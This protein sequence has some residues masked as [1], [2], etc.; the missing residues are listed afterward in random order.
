MSITRVQTH[1]SFM[2]SLFLPHRPFFQLDH[3]TTHNLKEAFIWY[4][5]YSD[6][7]LIGRIRVCT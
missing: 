6:P 1:F 5:V 4:S 7:L 3:W 2:H